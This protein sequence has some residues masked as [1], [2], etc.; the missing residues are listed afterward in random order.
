MAE[1]NET[2]VR[3][4]EVLLDIMDGLDVGSRDE[5]HSN[6]ALSGAGPAGY[7]P[8]L[9]CA[10][11]RA[12]WGYC[13]A[14]EDTGFTRSRSGSFDPYLRTRPGPFIHPSEAPPEPEPHRETPV[15]EHVPLNSVERYAALRLRV[16]LALRDLLRVIRQARPE[17]RA[18]ILERRRDG[19]EYVV[20]R[21]RHIPDV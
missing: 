2:L 20:K 21:M 1:V 3:R 12:V 4:V 8:C 14:C 15:G 16:R 17:M 11:N 13:P 10:A 19:L 6:G 18:W 5:M 7:E 9:G